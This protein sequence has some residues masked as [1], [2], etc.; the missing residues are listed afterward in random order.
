MTDENI[1]HHE[2]E[3]KDSQAHRPS[4]AQ[5][6]EEFFR[7]YGGLPESDSELRAIDGTPYPKPYDEKTEKTLDGMIAQ[8]DKDINTLST[9]ALN[10]HNSGNFGAEGEH[11]ELMRLIVAQNEQILNVQAAAVLYRGRERINNDLRWQALGK[12][13]SGTQQMIL[14]IGDMVAGLV[15]I[16][17]EP[18]ASETLE[19]PQDPFEHI[20][21]LFQPDEDHLSFC[22]KRIPPQYT[23]GMTAEEERALL[24]RPICID[25]YHPALAY[26]RQDERAKILKEQG[27]G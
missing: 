23:L 11:R 24:R 1:N 5:I 15:T 4:L 3:Q 14:A 7:E 16:L 20:Q 9:L 8:G 18:K 12:G 25:C 19:P 17:T 2:A 10:Y 21:H 6:F 13:N 26:I 22:G 27:K